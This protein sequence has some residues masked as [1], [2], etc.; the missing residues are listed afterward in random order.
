MTLRDRTRNINNNYN[1]T[2]II[3]NDDL[4][5]DS[6][7]QQIDIIKKKI[8]LIYKKYG[9]I[10]LTILDKT[11]IELVQN[12]ENKLAESLSSLSPS[13]KS[14]TLKENNNNT[15]N[16]KKNIKI[17]V[18]SKKQIVEK[19]DDTNSD[20][21]QILKDAA[22]MMVPTHKTVVSQPLP[23]NNENE[24]E[25]LE[26]LNDN[27]DNQLHEQIEKNEL[28][29]EKKELSSEFNTNIMSAEDQG[30]PAYQP[31]NIDTLLQAA[32]MFKK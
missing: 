21:P 3:N 7:I 30:D 32:K 25:S 17:D 4:D 16:T 20:M 23:S 1:K 8:D 5:D 2:E 15:I 29:E 19:T 24:Y 14:N 9:Q 6:I 27:E 18:V 12:F 13:K 22:K 11:I 10:G 31:N 26:N 28:E